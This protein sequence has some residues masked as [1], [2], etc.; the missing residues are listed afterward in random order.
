MSGWDWVG[1]ALVFGLA[2]ACEHVRQSAQIVLQGQHRADVTPFGHQKNL[3]VTPNF[4]HHER[5]LRSYGHQP[6]LSMLRLMAHLSL[7]TGAAAAFQSRAPSV[8]W[9]APAVPTIALRASPCRPAVL[10]AVNVKP[11]NLVT[12]AKPGAPPVRAATSTTTFASNTDGRNLPS[13]RIPLLGALGAVGF[14]T[15]KP[16]SAR[17]APISLS[18]TDSDDGLLHNW[19][20]FAMSFVILPMRAAIA[21]DS[22]VGII[23]LIPAMLF[24]GTNLGKDGLVYNPLI[25]LISL[26]L[27]MSF[28]SG[29]DDSTVRIIS[30]IPAMLFVGT[31]LGKEDSFR[32]NFVFLVILL[33]IQL[34]TYFAIF[35]GMTVPIIGLGLL[36]AIIAL[37]AGPV[38]D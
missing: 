12:T 15:T 31:N 35:G 22:A 17:S 34:S 10:D 33:L 23:S 3:G 18:T 11:S 36:S 25:W 5:A 16:A 19:L 29:T 6:Q 14:G 1:N 2:P 30:L 20:I 13:R 7:L 28:V 32:T 38:E 24:M 8:R 9:A 27:A 21:D 37:L 26:N 4:S